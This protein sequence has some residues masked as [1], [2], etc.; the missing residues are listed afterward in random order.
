MGRQRA[1]GFE[2]GSPGYEADAEPTE[3]ESLYMLFGL[4]EWLTFGSM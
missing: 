4:K 2:P 1:A 3:L